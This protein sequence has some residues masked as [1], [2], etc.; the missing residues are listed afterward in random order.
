MV[1]EFLATVFGA[2]Y[3]SGKYVGGKLDKAAREEDEKI[4]THIYE[5]DYK[6][7]FATEEDEQRVKKLIP[8][9]CFEIVGEDFREAVGEDYKKVRRVPRRSGSVSA[10]GLA[11]TPVRQ[12]GDESHAC[13]R[14]ENTE[15]I[16]QRKLSQR[17]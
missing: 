9:E 16:P 1:L 8:D 2:A 17:E 7:K 12:V 4:K 15:G 5:R 10:Q 14:R 6:P 13:Q 3:W 11:R